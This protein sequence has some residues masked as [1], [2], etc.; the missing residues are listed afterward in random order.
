[1]GQFKGKEG[2]LLGHV[3]KKYDITSR[4][5][6]VSEQSETAMVLETLVDTVSRTSDRDDERKAGESRA[7]G[8]TACGVAEESVD[9]V[10]VENLLKEF[11]SEHNPQKLR[12]VEKIATAYAGQERSLVR[13]FTEKYDLGQEK[14]KDMLLRLGLPVTPRSLDTDCITSESQ[15][16]DKKSR[17]LEDVNKRHD[18]ACK[19]AWNGLLA[20]QLPAQNSQVQNVV[21]YMVDNVS[22]VEEG[23]RM[24]LQSAIFTIEERGRE[25]NELSRYATYLC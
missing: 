5:R 8:S 25:A 22:K 13:K 16:V 19:E 6:L 3:V 24:S 21:N 20:F 14:E 18:E 2:L 23:T 12:A 4:V 7:S 11:Y 9:P 15:F 1:M 10:L 17:F